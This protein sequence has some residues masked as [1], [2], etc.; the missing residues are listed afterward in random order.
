MNA[1]NSLPA[2]GF[3][4]H[5]FTISRGDPAETSTFWEH[6][7]GWASNKK[8]NPA[9]NYKKIREILIGMVTRSRGG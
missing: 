2:V 4:R 8:T 6:K 7:V 1:T 3:G 5:G 9:K